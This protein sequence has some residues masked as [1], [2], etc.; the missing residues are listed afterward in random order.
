MGCAGCLYNF[1]HRTAEPGKAAAA[2]D[3]ERAVVIG[4]FI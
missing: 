1:I 4:L 2:V 3:A